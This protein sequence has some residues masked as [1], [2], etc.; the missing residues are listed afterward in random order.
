MKNIFKKR[1][2][3]LVQKGWMRAIDKLA[4]EFDPA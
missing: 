1:I 2:T 3:S 4:P